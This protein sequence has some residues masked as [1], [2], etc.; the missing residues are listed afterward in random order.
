MVVS[1]MRI[2]I[3][4]RHN[5]LIFTMF[6]GILILIIYFIGDSY[7]TNISISKRAVL[8]RLQGIANTSAYMMDRDLL[9]FISIELVHLRR[10]EM[11]PLFDD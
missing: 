5:R 2:K 1:T 3:K 10:I 4:K 8:D 6:S 7:F 11:E 9:Q